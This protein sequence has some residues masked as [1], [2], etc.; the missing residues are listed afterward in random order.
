[1]ANISTTKDRG[2]PTVSLSWTYSH[3]SQPVSPGLGMNNLASETNSNTI[4]TRINIP[5]FD[6]F[7]HAWKV[8]EARDH[9]TQE[10]ATLDDTRRKI[11]RNVW[12]AYEQY[13]TATAELQDSR[14][15]ENYSTGCAVSSAEKI[16]KRGCIYTRPDLSRKLSTPKDSSVD[17]LADGQAPISL[18]GRNSRQSVATTVSE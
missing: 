5:L 6:G 4:A 16:P 14:M 17:R 12:A 13:R 15:V 1:M 9:A 2:L 7:D 8:Q 18:C 10:T 3:D 11:I